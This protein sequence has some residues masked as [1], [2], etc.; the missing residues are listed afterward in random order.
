MMH[1]FYLNDSDRSLFSIFANFRFNVGDV[2]SYYDQKSSDYVRV[3]I[4]DCIAACLMPGYGG[5]PPSV[6]FSYHVGILKD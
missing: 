3:K 1:D 4:L 2:V 6:A 5:G